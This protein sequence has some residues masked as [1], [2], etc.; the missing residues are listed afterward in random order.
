M[1]LGVAH[2]YSHKRA[3]VH[4]WLFIS[5]DKTFRQHYNIHPRLI[6]VSTILQ[7]FPILPL[8]FGICL[9]Q[10]PSLSPLVNYWLSLAAELHYS[11]VVSAGVLRMERRV[12]MTGWK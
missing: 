3:Q 2:R 4:I 6:M 9:L 7:P 8:Q 10:L 12:A 5:A 1:D 11:F